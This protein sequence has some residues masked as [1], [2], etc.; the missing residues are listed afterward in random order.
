MNKIPGAPKGARIYRGP[1][2]REIEKQSKWE[3]ELFKTQKIYL[4]HPLP[5]WF[6]G[7]GKEWE[8]SRRGS[9][10]FD[11]INPTVNGNVWL[12]GFRIGFSLGD[13]F[14]YIPRVQ[15]RRHPL[16]LIRGGVTERQVKAV[17]RRYINQRNKSAK[18]YRDL[19]HTR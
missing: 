2:L 8:I 18:Y 16:V 6:S 11:S 13:V 4:D 14:I 5:S 15:D 17:I 7:I 12:R 3:K 19:K 9:P 10:N 1:G